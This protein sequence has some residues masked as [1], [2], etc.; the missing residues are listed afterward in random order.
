[1][2]IPRGAA[3]DERSMSILRAARRMLAEVLGSEVTD[4]TARN[5][6]RDDTGRERV[7]RDG[8]ARARQ[9][10][11]AAH[12]DFGFRRPELIARL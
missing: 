5:Q 8:N 4:C 2:L 10:T 7:V 1:M 12:P 9:V 11:L 3:V 6:E